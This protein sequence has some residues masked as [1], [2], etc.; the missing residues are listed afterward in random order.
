[1]ATAYPFDPSGTSAANRVNNEQH[2][3]TSQNFRDY[4]YIIPKFA[5]F[6]EN[7]IAIRMQNPNGTVRTLTKGID[8]Y[9]ANQFLDAS[10]ACA[11][12]VF[13]AISFL[14]TD[15]SGILSISYN[16]MGGDWTLTTAEISRILAEEMRNPRI[17]AWEQITNLPVRFPVVSHEWNLVDMVGASKVVESLDGIRNTILSINGGGLANHISNFLNPH[18][19]TKS[20]VGLGN[21]LDFPVAT[22][23]EAREGTLNSA[24]MTPLRVAQ[25]VQTKGAALIAAHSSDTANPHNTNKDQIGLGSVANYGLATQAQAE[26]GIVNTAYMTPLRVAQAITAKVGTAFTTHAADKLNPHNVT[27]DQVGLFNVQNFPVATFEEARAATANDRYMTPLRT[28]QLV[29]EVSAGVNSAHTT[30]TD[31]PHSV[32]FDQVGAYS[33]NQ[34]DAK[35]TNY[36]RL[37]DS[38]IAGMSADVFTANLLEKTIANST[39]FNGKTSTQFIDDLTNTYNNV[40]SRMTYGWSRDKSTTANPGTTPYRWIRLGIVGTLSNSQTASPSSIALSHP[41]AYWLFSGGHKQESTAAINAVMTSPA[42]LIHAKNGGNTPNAHHF[43]VTRLSFG[44]TTDVRF[45]YTYDSVTGVMSVWVRVAYAYNDINVTRLTS[46]ANSQV[47][48]DDSLTNEP[49]GIVYSTPTAYLSASGWN[50]DYNALETRITALETK[51]NSIT[52]E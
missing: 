38:W 4:H 41:D 13:G 49:A 29:A 39:K 31:N 20:Q 48:G 2:V 9:F 25:A 14:D 33:R 42:Y 15:T 18:K 28:A 51:M 27:K 32:T 17:T 24:Y 40:F 46:L 50:T 36:V 47:V 23:Q 35:F 34:V 12:P 45:G 52:V 37:N 21:V 10:R 22:E 43:D 1:M 11:K 6:F 7:N 3:I 19:V 26:A 44:G 16:T 8:Y 30:R 5:P